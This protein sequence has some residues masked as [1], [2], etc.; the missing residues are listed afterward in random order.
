MLLILMVW[1]GFLFIMVS[2]WLLGVIFNL[3]LY[4]IVVRL[5]VFFCL[6][7]FIIEFLLLFCC[8]C[9][10]FVLKECLFFSKIGIEILSKSVVI[11]SNI[12]LFVGC[13][14]EVF[15]FWSMW[16]MWSLKFDGLLLLRVSE[17]RG[18]LCLLLWVIWV[19]LVMWSKVLV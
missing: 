9:L 7:W 19:I 2:Y 16:R 14:F 18:V 17:V 10:R 8:W 6:G 11:D 13:S 4:L 5:N 15:D 12:V 1:F 3:S